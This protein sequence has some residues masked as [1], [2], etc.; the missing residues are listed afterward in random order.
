MAYTPLPVSTNFSWLAN[1]NPVQN[2][3]DAVT[4][5]QQMKQRA[6]ADQ[7]QQIQN[8]YL[9]PQL[10]AKTL[11]M[12]LA[13]TGTQLRQQYIAPEEQ[14]K[15]NYM[16]QQ[17]P[18]L[19][20]QTASIQ[21]GT[22]LKPLATLI[23]AQNAL[24]KQNQMNMEN[25]RWGGLYNF[26]QFI[27][28][29]N[30]TS[31]AVFEAQNPELM[32]DMAQLSAKMS[33]SNNGN[34]SHPTSS[35]LT[36]QAF[37]NAGIQINPSAFGNYN[38]QATV[39][40]QTGVTTQNIP[41]NP[42]ASISNQNMASNLT[43]NQAQWTNNYLTSLL[44][45]NT[46]MNQINP[47]KVAQNYSNNQVQAAQMPSGKSLGQSL[48]QQNQ[49]NLNPDSNNQLQKSFEAYANKSLDPEMYHRYLAGKA[50]MAFVNNPDINQAMNN[51]KHYATI[52]TPEKLLYAKLNNPEAYNQY[53]NAA[54]N[55]VQLMGGNIAALEGYRSSNQG[56]NKAINYFN[57]GLKYLKNDP[58]AALNYMNQAKALLTDEF[59]AVSQSANTQFPVE[60]EKFKPFSSVP[61]QNLPSFTQS[62]AQNNNSANAQV[63]DMKTG[64]VESNLTPSQAKQL[65]KQF[66]KRF[67]ESK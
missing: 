19:Q 66:P 9:Q 35:L 25:S 67:K 29:M 26:R 4:Q 39:T 7:A 53:E 20:S 15:L 43:P 47:E 38:S 65:I 32:K 59:N 51:L 24:N 56:I 58:Q 49:F 61:Q 37:Q 6:L 40:P 62:Q 36:P 48:N 17:A 42:N 5:V 57:T 3:L 50:A 11:G 10:A 2:A 64:K 27:E 12:Q 1:V 45:G 13:N 54:H 46:G 31:R 22:K 28:T 60:P 33:L 16:K 55:M 21:E 44:H 30:P 63:Y 41:V 23:T 8:Q 52:F 34:L 14:A 18:N